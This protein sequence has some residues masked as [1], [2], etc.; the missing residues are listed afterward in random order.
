MVRVSILS[1]FTC[2]VSMALCLLIVSPMAS[3]AENSPPKLENTIDNVC[4]KPTRQHAAKVPDDQTV[5][6]PVSSNLEDSNPSTLVKNITFIGNTAISDVELSILLEGCL[7]K[8]YDFDGLL[9]LA[10]HVTNYYRQKKFLFATAIFPPQ[11]VTKG[12]LII[13][14]IEGEYGVVKT[15]G[16]PDLADPAAA[17][18]LK[19]KPGDVI[20]EDV[21]N[22]TILVM[23]EL[24]GIRVKP[25]ITAGEKQGQGDLDVLVLKED[26]WSGSLLIDNHGEKSTGKNSITL[27]L[28]A[29]NLDAFGDRLSFSAMQTDESLTLFD[30]KYDRPFGFS[31][32]RLGVSIG[33]NKYNLTGDFSDFSGQ[34]TDYKGTFS[35]PYILTPERKLNGVFSYNISKRGQFLGTTLTDD[36][37]TSGFDLGLEFEQLYKSKSGRSTKTNLNLI[38]ENL[39][40]AF[41]PDESQKYSYLKGWL[42]HREPINNKLIA[43]L[44]LSFQNSISKKSHS[45][46]AYSLGGPDNVRAYSN[47]KIAGPSGYHASLELNYNIG[48][49]SP[50][51]FYDYGEISASS[52]EN[53]KSLAGAGFGARTKF[54]DL[55]TEILFA[56]PLEN[57]ETDEKDPRLWVRVQRIF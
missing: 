11:T 9:N 48:G 42:Q 56:F 8:A 36:I 53:K 24:P 57:T 27:N 44:G 25:T 12:I 17:F 5:G 15:S 46:N 47:G 22:R 40:S 23:E 4:D 34:V 38:V 39:N 41:N 13:R 45:L 16:E 51:I 2:L 32:A 35:Y 28:K 29:S 31:G 37:Y 10:K 52:G 19:L 55:Y 43:S 26:T 30:L 18:L 54:K 33:K 14:V 20:S 21:L 6:D 50:F 3:N 1:Q 7:G 49:L